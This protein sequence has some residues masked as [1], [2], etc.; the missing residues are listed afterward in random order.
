MSINLYTPSRNR[1]LLGSLPVASNAL[2]LSNSDIKKLTMI[3]KLYGANMALKK[4][5]NIPSDHEQYVKLFMFLRLLISKT[6]DKN[7]VLLYQIA[8][9]TLTGAVNSYSLYGINLSLQIDKQNLQKKINDIL[10]GKN[11]KVVEFAPV[12]GQL[13]VQK[14]F[15]LAAVFNYYIL[16]YGMPAYGVGFDPV[17]ISFLTGVLTN[18]GIN[19]YK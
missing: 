7:L 19:P 15:T 5:E 13:A 17:K 1:S 9:D 3:E 14:V 12:T 2:A 10:T 16:I 8:Q 4:N 6:R 11:E 18:M